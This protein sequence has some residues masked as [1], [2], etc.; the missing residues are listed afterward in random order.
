MKV[1]PHLDAQV[2]C[3]HPAAHLPMKNAKLSTKLIVLLAMPLLALLIVGLRGAGE[4]W[5]IVRD[6]A[7]LEGNAAI[8]ERIGNVAHELQRERGRSAVFINSKG[9]AFAT[10]L[11]AQR[12][13]TDRQ[14][15]AL[16]EQLTGF[17]AAAFGADFERLLKAGL[18]ALGQLSER[19]D[20]ISGLRITAAESTEHYTRTIAVLLDIVVG[21]SRLSKDAEVAD[22]I[23]CYVNFLQGKEQAGIERATLA[24]VFT[25]DKF[26]G[27]TFNRWAKA[28]AAQETFFRVFRSFASAAQIAFFSGQVRGTEVDAVVTLRQVALDK[29]NEGA[30]GIPP[31]AWFDASTKRIDLMKAV[32]DRL[33]SDYGQTA[34]RIKSAATQSFYGYALTTALA[35]VITVGFGFWTIRSIVVPLRRAADSLD[36]GADQV[37]SAAG[38]VSGSSQSLA[39]GAS[40][41]AAALEETSATL[42]EIS[43]MTKRNADTAG[44]AR[45][46]SGETRVAADAGSGEMDAM[47]EAMDAIR[48]SAANIGKIVKSIDEIAFQ[49]NI[50]ALNAAVEAARAG[51]AGAGFA[52][53]AD[54]VRALAQRSALAAKETAEKIADAVCKSERGVEISARVALNF[55]EIVGKARQ[56]DTL[57]AEIATASIEQGSGVGQV[58]TAVAQMDKVTQRNAATAEGTAAAAEELN[59][60][61]N[62]MSGRVGDV[63]RLVNGARPGAARH[64]SQRPTGGGRIS[65]DMQENHAACEEMVLMTGD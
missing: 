20:A 10:E 52:V 61:S 32:E 48:A 42:E 34:G 12:Q 41:Q 40:E 4:K 43:S 50:L 9:A 5:G 49:T 44:Q 7:R 16:H 60:Q 15:G 54:E 22:G 51:E 39:E 33:A 2:I 56:V 58:N 46:L 6:Y 38:E 24:G 45:K 63:L 13:A 36:A 11:P 31:S 47:K 25:L 17:R 29:R 53:V 28:V 27:D 62:E 26:S 59:A 23:H 57:I 1:G 3:V 64:A 18:A 35:L 30:F 19:R 8:M 37:R 21:M 65:P 14:T 55:T